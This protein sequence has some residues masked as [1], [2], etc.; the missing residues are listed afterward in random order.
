M[1]TP[2]ALPSLPTPP[3]RGAVRPQQVW[4]ALTPRQQQGVLRRIVLVCQ[5]LLAT[6]HHPGKESSHD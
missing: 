5:E 3:E 2:P 6:P 4:N 1:D